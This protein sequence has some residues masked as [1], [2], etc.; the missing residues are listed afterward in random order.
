MLVIFMVIDVRI[1]GGI[2]YA[3]ANQLLKT[4]KVT[5]NLLNATV[6]FRFRAALLQPTY[7]RRPTFAQL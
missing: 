6:F 3:Q 1:G 7:R 2:H 5:Q 4:G